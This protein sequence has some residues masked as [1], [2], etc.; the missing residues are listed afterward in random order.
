MKWAVAI[1]LV[2]VS[3]FAQDTDAGASSTAD[4]GVTPL[5]VF[6]HPPPDGGGEPL[7]A[8]IFGLK[9]RASGYAQVD[10]VLYDQ[11]SLDEINPA[12]GAPLN[13]EAF[14]VRHAHLKV[15]LERWIFSGLA[16]V[17][18][19]T[20][21]G[22]NVRLYAASLAARWPGGEQ[23]PLVEAR[24]GLIRIPF[25]HDVRE[26]PLHRRFLE[27]STMV[28]ALF[29]GYFDLGGELSG[30]WRALHYELAVMNGEPVG[31]RAFPAA[32]PNAS[33]DLVGRLG[34]NGR[35][36]DR[37]AVELGA[38]GLWGSGFHR[39]SP[40]TKDVLVWHDANEDGQ[41]QTSEL[42]VLGGLPATPS[43]NF[44]RFALGAD[45][46]A[47]LAVPVLGE[48]ELV[49]EL[50]WGKNLDRALYV[51]DPVALGHDQ[52]ELG[53]SL[54]L[55]QQLPLG[56]LA[57]VRYDTYNPDADAADQQGAYRVPVDISVSTVSVMAAWRWRTTARL[58]AEY[59]HQRNAF[60]RS[61][62]G[63]PMTLGADR[64]TLRGEVAF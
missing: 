16:E 19:N 26:E 5:P 48:L 9:V 49:G 57:G 64:F 56:F 14:S 61:P 40:A 55:V 31:E 28:Q 34:V 52:R 1:A 53:W 58:I 21:G 6:D 38:S 20:V 63:T 45:L 37:L 12:T 11:A 2:S 13:T 54:A 43:V 18:G 59:D 35:L 62:N 7:A 50:I 60:G 44:G 41:V 17:D 24:A 36:F 51:S 25:G 42:Q 22:V 32:D 23:A 30:S 47:A 15:E 8:D 10:A 3:A 29:P 4:G 27:P 33:K 46:R 39:G